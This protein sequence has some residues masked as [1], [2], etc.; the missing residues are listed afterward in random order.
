MSPLPSKYSMGNNGTFERTTIKKMKEKIKLT[1][2]KSQTEISKPNNNS[3]DKAKKCMSILRKEPLASPSQNKGRDDKL[4]TIDLTAQ[5]KHFSAEKA[6]KLVS[7][8]I[9]DDK[10][11]KV[12][13]RSPLI[14]DKKFDS[15]IFSPVS[16][17]YEDKIINGSGLPGKSSFFNNRAFSPRKTLDFADKS[18]EFKGRTL[19]DETY[20]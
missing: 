19:F 11:N 1:P 15:S 14:P 7:K 16:S 9:K 18:N 5:K 8:I 17:N 12:P 10:D 6:K 13:K 20:E 4:N 3:A 2:H